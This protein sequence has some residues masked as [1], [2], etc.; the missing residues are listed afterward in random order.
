M[1]L[2]TAI[3]IVLGDLVSL[4]IDFVGVGAVVIMAQKSVVVIAPTLM[5]VAAQSMGSVPEFVVTGA[6]AALAV[7][8]TALLAC[9][10]PVHVEVIEVGAGAVGLLSPVYGPSGISSKPH[11]SKMSSSAYI[12]SVFT[13][14]SASGHGF[15]S[16]GSGIASSMSQNLHGSCSFRNLGRRFRLFCVT[17]LKQAAST[18]D[19]SPA[20]ST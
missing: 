14:L 6:Q 3:L 13:V 8:G 4:V 15:G 1:L 12:I 18:M 20:E 5:V 19:T 9:E 10:E 11:N 16:N 7:M 17:A 2:V